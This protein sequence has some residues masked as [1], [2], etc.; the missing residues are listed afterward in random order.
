MNEFQFPN[1]FSKNITKSY[2]LLLQTYIFSIVACKYSQQ[3]PV[4]KNYSFE[5]YVLCR[6]EQ[7]KEL[8][9]LSR[10]NCKINKKLYSL[11]ICLYATL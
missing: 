8:V 10:I 2:F 1:Y 6:S 9:S 11:L 3:T 4:D 7:T 5:V